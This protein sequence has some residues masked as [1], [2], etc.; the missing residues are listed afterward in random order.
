MKIVTISD[1]P[2]LFSGLAKVHRNVIDGL[3]EEGHEVVPCVWF[4][5]TTKQLVLIKSGIKLPPPLYK[6]ITLLPMPKNDN[7][8]LAAYDI[9]E[10]HKPDIVI[11][12]GDHWE[13]YYMHAIKGKL[14][15]SFKWIGYFTIEENPI[16]EKWIPLFKYVDEI[17]VP[18]EFGRKSILSS[19]ENKNVK[20]IPYGVD[21]IFNIFPQD[22]IKKLRE[23]R[24]VSNKIRFITV[25]QN[26]LRKNLPSILQTAQILKNTGKNNISFYIHTNTGATDP[27]ETY[28]YDLI[29]LSKKLEVQDMVSFPTKKTSIFSSQ[30]EH[31]LAEEYNASNYYLCTSY[32]EGYGLSILEAMACGLSVWANPSTTMFE[33]LG[34]N[35]LGETPRGRL[36]D[37]KI[38]ILPP[39]KLINSIDP[40]KLAMEI[41]KYAKLENKEQ[42]DICRK[43][44][45]NRTWKLMKEELCKVINDIDMNI[46]LPIEEV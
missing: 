8:P 36:L 19:T 4:P 25:A 31:F 11:T 40:H 3:L 12:I 9:I 21:D 16:P 5:Y 27:S 28:I 24:N 23:D 37:G 26:T 10:K 15:Y 13:F 45:M 6:K 33:L 32:S 34:A 14:N 46:S 39:D 17:I 20:T 7:A 2:N 38:D 43:Y 44:S 22:E 41:I 1:N 42:K 18:S 30:P 29:S 35:E